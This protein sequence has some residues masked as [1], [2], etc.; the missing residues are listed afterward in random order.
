M[1]LV[2][3][4]NVVPSVTMPDARIGAR[5]ALRLLQRR[6]MIGHRL[7]HPTLG[8]LRAN[9]AL[10]PNDRRLR[11]T[12]AL[13]T[14]ATAEGL[15][16]GHLR[17]GTPSD[18]RLDLDAMHAYRDAIRASDGAPVVRYAATLSPGQ[19]KNYDDGLAAIRAYPT[20]EASLQA[21]LRQ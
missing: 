19:T 11:T 7:T 15:L 6:V 5:R 20:D 8:P 16:S 18:L 9:S 17:S 1:N 3:R 4:I 13:R 2:P 21:T 10:Q 14:L 12:D